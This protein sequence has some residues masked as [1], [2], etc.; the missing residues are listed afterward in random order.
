MIDFLLLKSLHSLLGLTITVCD[1]S[2]SVIKEYKSDKTISLFYNH[3]FILSNFSKTQ[4]DFLFHYGSL[5][6]LFL[7]HHIQQY[8]IIIGPWRSNAIDPLFLKKKLTEIKI[9]AREQD[10]FIDRLSQLPF[11]SLNQ[12]RELLIVTNYCL[13]GVVK[14]KLSEPLHYYTKGWSSSFDLDKIR[15]F[16]NQNLSSYKYQYR[17]ENNILK[18]VKSGSESLLKETVEHFSNAIVPIIS[19]DELRSEK[20]YSIIIYDRLSQATIQV[21]LDIETAYRARDRFIKETESIISLNEVLKLRDTAILFYT[22]QVNSLNKHIVTPHSQ[23]I[24]TVIQ[25]LENNLNR[26]VK[27]EEIAK[28]C[29]MSESKLRKLFKQEKHITIHQYF[30][31][32]KI[33]TAKQLLDENKKVEEVSNLLGFSTSSNFSRT[34]KKIVGI[35][36]LEYKEKL[37]PI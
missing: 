2:F 10:Y 37:K 25:Y 6:E 31:N 15:Q 16:S 28:A 35:S 13:T 14:D 26:F 36:P 34:F 9:N 17:F 5:G 19:G 24:L 30:L 11:F 7:V 27:T 32:L 33:E 20:N 22:Q 4:Q 29:H 12:I 3:Y 23:T 21:G 18:A 1:Q 8:Y